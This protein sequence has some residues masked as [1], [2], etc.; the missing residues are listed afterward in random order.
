MSIAHTG[1]HATRDNLARVLQLQFAGN[2]LAQAEDC[3]QTALRALESTPHHEAAARAVAE[4]RRAGDVT[5]SLS[6]RL[7]FIGAADAH[8]ADALAA[9]HE[10]EPCSPEFSRPIPPPIARFD[11]V[12]ANIRTVVMKHQRPERFVFVPMLIISFPEPPKG[13]T[14]YGVF[15]IDAWAIQQGHAN[16]VKQDFVVHQPWDGDTRYYGGLGGGP[17]SLPPE[18]ICERFGA[19]HYGCVRQGTSWLCADH[20][21]GDEADREA[22]LPKEPEFR[23]LMDKAIEEARRLAPRAVR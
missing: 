8:I 4:L 20:L 13:T 18:A 12:A 17:D 10:E 22:R 9:L 19:P 1:L 23:R 15:S 11:A 3:L 5:A 14:V 16:F 2:N 6:L 21:Y 7:G